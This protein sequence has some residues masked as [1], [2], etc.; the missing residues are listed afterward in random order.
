MTRRQHQRRGMALIDAVVGGLI[1]AVGLGVIISMVARSIAAHRKGER[2]IVASW[3]ADEKLNMVLLE[4]PEV[5][6]KLHDTTGRFDAPFEEFAYEVWFDNPTD[7][8]PFE[9]T[10]TIDWGDGDIRD[11]KDQITVDTIIARR[12]GDPLQLR[13]PAEPID[14]EARYFPEDDFGGRADAPA[15]PTP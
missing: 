9:V 3:L 2:M 11:G 5:F 10:V 4:G 13:E 8:A 14:R 6:P 15:T 7:Y 12:Q 1:L